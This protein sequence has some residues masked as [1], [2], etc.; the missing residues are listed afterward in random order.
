[1]GS[2]ISVGGLA[3][4]EDEMGEEEEMARGEGEE[5]A[6]DQ[7]DSRKDVCRGISNVRPHYKQASRLRNYVLFAID[8][9]KGCKAVSMGN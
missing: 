6:I 5:R 7:G 4:K 8:Y 9:L 2:C 1:M 3:H